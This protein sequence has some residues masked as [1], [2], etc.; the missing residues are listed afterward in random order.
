MYRHL[1]ASDILI[2]IT[3]GPQI[4][5]GDNLVIFDPQEE[6][7]SPNKGG[8]MTNFVDE[9]YAYP[10]Q[11]MAFGAAVT[12]TTKSFHGTII[13]LPLRTASQAVCSRIKVIVVAE[14][15]LLYR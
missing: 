2:Q 3:D 4:L 15:Q 8:L 13:R 6:L 14:A 7:A 5:S 12:D 1:V 11:L 9:G 10:D